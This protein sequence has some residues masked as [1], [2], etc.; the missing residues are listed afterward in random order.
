MS[1]YLTFIFPDLLVSMPLDLQVPKHR[2]EVDKVR[3]ESS[4][5]SYL[6]GNMKEEVFYLLAYL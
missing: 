3:E 4:A 1:C 2:W 6:H 5:V